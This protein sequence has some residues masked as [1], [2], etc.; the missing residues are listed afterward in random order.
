LRQAIVHCLVQ[1]LI[2][3]GEV[4]A[5]GLLT[6]TA[7]VI[8]GGRTRGREGEG[9]GMDRGPGSGVDTDVTAHH[10]SR[11]AGYCYQ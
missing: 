3:Q 10:H 2:D 8:L 4:L 6:H 1:Q 7:T 9:D 11:V 5:D